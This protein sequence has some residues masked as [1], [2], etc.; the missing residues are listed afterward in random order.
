MTSSLGQ[1]VREW[2]KQINCKIELSFPVNLDLS[3]WEECHSARK[4]MMA[5]PLQSTQ[6][7]AHNM[8]M[9]RNWIRVNCIS[10]LQC[11]A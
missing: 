8:C 9:Y 6:K 11:D 2:D 7:Y 1:K 3:P 5:D 4:P 10:R